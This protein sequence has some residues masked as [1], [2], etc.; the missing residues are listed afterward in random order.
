MAWTVRV[1]NENGDPLENDFDI[2]FEAIPS[3][4]AYPICSSVARYYVTLLNPPQ[5]KTF[6]YEWDSAAKVPEFSHLEKSRLVRDVA[7]RCSDN[8]LYLRFMG[9]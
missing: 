1:Q 9:D 7:E 4:D 5:L 6:V 8:Q 3:G 2:G